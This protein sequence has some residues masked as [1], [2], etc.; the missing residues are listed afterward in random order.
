MVLEIA[1]G[2]EAGGADDL[3]AAGADEQ[4]RRVPVVVD[5]GHRE[6]RGA[7]IA[8]EVEL[9]MHQAPIGAIDLTIDQLHELTGTGLDIAVL[10]GATIEEA[11]R[12]DV[13][14]LA[15]DARGDDDLLIDRVTRQH[16]AIGRG[17]EARLEGVATVGEMVARHRVARAI[18]PGAD[19]LRHREGAWR[20]IE[21]AISP[22]AWRGARDADDLFVGHI[23]RVVR[24]VVGHTVWPTTST[25]STTQR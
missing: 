10:A 3:D 23:G 16:A 1:D 8:I 21:R 2:S 13:D 12:E 25:P 24:G 11:H 4:A 17:G 5:V 20:A 6:A 9:V 18:A 7:E 14:H 19:T 22:G 15:L